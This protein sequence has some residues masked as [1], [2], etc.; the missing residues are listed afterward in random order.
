MSHLV[1]EGGGE[2]ASAWDTEA[3]L[4][5]IEARW[6]AAETWRNALLYPREHRSGEVAKRSADELARRVVEWSAAPRP[7]S[8][9]HDA[10]E[11]IM[12]GLW[13]VIELGWL[14]DLPPQVLRTRS[15]PLTRS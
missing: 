7:T 3:R 5:Q 6:V 10:A 9:R 1:V 14:T 12:V 2:L 4:R 11:A 15:K 8:L 13:G